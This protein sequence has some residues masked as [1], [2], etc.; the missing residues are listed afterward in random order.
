M[1]SSG[2]DG[3]GKMPFLSRRQ[4][5]VKGIHTFRDTRAPALQETRTKHHAKSY[6]E[7]AWAR[8]RG[9][10]MSPATATSSF[11]ARRKRGLRARPMASGRGQGGVSGTKQCCPPLRTGSL[12]PTHSQHSVKVVPTP[13]ILLA[14][15][16]LGGRAYVNAGEY[17]SVGGVSEYRG[18]ISVQKGTGMQKEYLNTEEYLHGVSACRG[19]ISMQRSISGL[20]SI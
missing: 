1:T 14:L 17:L 2:P 6:E 16:H 15:A 5:Q 13:P 10:Q 4:K 19:S 12:A 9:V 3:S 8:P 7:K 18:S 11:T 20:G